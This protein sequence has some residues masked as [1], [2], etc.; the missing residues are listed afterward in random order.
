M[1]HGKVDRRKNAGFPLGPAMDNNQ[2]KA[3]EAIA[4][5]LAVVIP[6]F[7]KLVHCSFYRFI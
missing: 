3:H 6:M 4:I 1:R 2:A 7:K 5:S